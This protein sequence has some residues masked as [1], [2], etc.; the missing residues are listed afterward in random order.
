[1][2]SAFG[3]GLMFRFDLQSNANHSDADYRASEEEQNQK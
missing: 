1:M 3:Y 2:M